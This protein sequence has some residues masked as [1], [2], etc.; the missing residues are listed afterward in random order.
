[1]K[2]G[3]RGQ[4]KTNRQPTRPKRSGHA[5]AE[6]WEPWATSLFLLPPSALTLLCVL[7]CDVLA[8][9]RQNEKSIELNEWKSGKCINEWMTAGTVNSS[10]SSSI[11]LAI[12]FVAWQ[13]PFSA[14]Q[15]CRRTLRTYVSDWSSM[16]VWA[17]RS[18]GSF[19]YKKTSY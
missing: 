6:G 7:A 3:S 9:N 15:R 2:H 16:C 1:M 18:R 17:Q 8:R 14:G 5:R 11:H 4:D 10:R 12:C 19:H 13:P